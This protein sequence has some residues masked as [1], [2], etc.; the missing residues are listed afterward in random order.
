MDALSFSSQSQKENK[1]PTGKVTLMVMLAS[2]C[3]WASP[4][5]VSQGAVGTALSSTQ[6]VP[7]CGVS[8]PPPVTAASS[9]VTTKWRGL[10]APR[11]EFGLKNRS[12]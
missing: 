12:F 5:P 2:I 3:K 4:A 8:Q 7:V 1:T 6:Q 11:P 10:R 9:F